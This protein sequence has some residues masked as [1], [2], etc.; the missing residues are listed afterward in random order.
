M[1]LTILCV[2]AT[3]GAPTATLET[4]EGIHRAPLPSFPRAMSYS[5]EMRLI[6]GTY[7]I[8]AGNNFSGVH[9]IVRAPATR[10]PY[11]QRRDIL[12]A[13]RPLV[14][15]TQ[16]HAPARSHVP[17][18]TARIPRHSR[19]AYLASDR[20]AQNSDM[21]LGRTDWL[22]TCPHGTCGDFGPS[23]T[24]VGVTVFGPR[25]TTYTT[26][27]AHAAARPSASGP[28]QCFKRTSPWSAFEDRWAEN[29]TYAGVFYVR[30]RLVH[31]WDGCVPFFVQR[32]QRVSRYYADYYTGL[33]VALIN[34]KQ[35]LFYDDV[36]VGVPP[37]SMFDLSAMP[38]QSDEDGTAGAL[39]HAI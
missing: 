28:V 10:T 31:A 35:E 29:A 8:F 6:P 2:A 5:C 16:S 37:P 39:P 4:E 30:G 15:L 27:L 1:M 19:P 3:S 11:I 23:P 17:H 32:V 18:A 34:E 9:Y 38:C 12:T 33:P 7:D 20:A 13:T 14:R 22:M 36:K 24:S 25:N 26:T 21:N